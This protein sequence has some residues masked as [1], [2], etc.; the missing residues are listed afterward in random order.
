MKSLPFSMVYLL[1]E[2]ESVKRARSTALA[3]A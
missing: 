2:S 1:L 3:R